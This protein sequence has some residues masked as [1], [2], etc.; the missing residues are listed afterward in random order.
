MLNADRTECMTVIISLR[1]E[2]NV[3][4]LLFIQEANL[5]PTWEHPLPVVQRG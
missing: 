4:V 1:E 5:A 3:F 2:T